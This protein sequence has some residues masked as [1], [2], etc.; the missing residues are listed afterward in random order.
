VQILREKRVDAIVI[1]A[2]RLGSLYLPLLERLAVPVVLV[3]NQQEGRYV[4]SVGTDNLQGGRLAARYLVGLGHT[5]LGFISGPEWA[6]Q[7]TLRLEGALLEL[8]THGLG[9]DPVNIVPGNGRC[10]GGHEAM[11][12]LLRQVAPP[13][14][15]LCYNDLTAIGAMRAAQQAGLRVPDDLSIIGYDDVAYASYVAP[16]L[17]TIR[18][19]MFEMGQKATEMALALLS[20]GEAVENVLVP[21]QL[22]ERAS[23]APPASHGHAPAPV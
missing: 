10:E 18:Q 4:Y 2:S 1:T 15:L 8:R 11:A 3:N 16:P 5:R 21:G 14:A 19:Q 17:T 6:V 20:G 7:S 9:F 23:C 13:T 22:V 12:G